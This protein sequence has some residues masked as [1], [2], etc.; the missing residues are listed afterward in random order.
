QILGLAAEPLFTRVFRWHQAMAQ[1]QV[2]H[3]ERIARIEQKLSEIPGL[4]LA[5]NAYHGI[6]VPD[7]VREGIEAAKRAAGV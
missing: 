2:G 1:Y 6:G 7:C 4:A 3:L 5:G